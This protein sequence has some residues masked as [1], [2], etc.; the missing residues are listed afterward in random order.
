MK[1]QI[2]REINQK[3]A[4]VVNNVFGK[5]DEHDG[6]ANPADNK[7][8]GKDGLMILKKGLVEGKRQC[9]KH[10]RNNECEA[11]DVNKPPV[12]GKVDQVDKTEHAVKQNKSDEK[13]SQERQ[14]IRFVCLKKLLLVVSLNPLR[15]DKLTP[16]S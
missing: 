10:H 12:V 13:P 4:A 14:A 11:N 5:H 9:R 2:S 16:S 7:R 6:D 3:Q 15:S 1:Q 8:R